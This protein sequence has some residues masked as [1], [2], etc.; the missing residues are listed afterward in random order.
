MSEPPSLNSDSSSTPRAFDNSPREFSGTKLIIG[1][2]V[3]ATVMSS[4]LWI[5]WYLHARPFQPLQL[6]IHQAYPKSY[7]QVQGG[8]LKIHKN[9]PRILRITLKVGFDPKPRE[10]DEQVT[11]MVARLEELARKHINLPSY[12][13]LE[14]HLVQRVPE[15][16]SRTRTVTREIG[17]SQP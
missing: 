17:R 6:A 1:L 11:A 16:D 15:H 4:G 12:E 9:T 5:F 8:Q 14:V 13:L 10:S 3:F 7:P 2:F